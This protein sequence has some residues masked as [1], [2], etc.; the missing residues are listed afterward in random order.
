[1]ESAQKVN[2]VLRDQRSNEL[3]YNG[4][5]LSLYVNKE[6]R[7]RRIG[8]L[9]KEAKVLLMDR[10]R[11]KHFYNNILGFGFNYEAVKRVCTKFELWVGLRVWDGRMKGKKKVWDKYLLLPSDILQHG[12]VM[13]FSEQGFETQIF[14]SLKDIRQLAKWKDE[15]PFG[16]QTAG[17]ML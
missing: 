1:M 14:L 16:E 3:T 12:S 6:G 9:H 11:K 15:P 2:F 5:V 13:Q 10:D 17:I 8:I 4:M 7:K